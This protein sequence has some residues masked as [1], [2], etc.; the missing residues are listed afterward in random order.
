MQE[1]LLDRHSFKTRCIWYDSRLQLRLDLLAQEAIA[2]HTDQQNQA[3]HSYILTTNVFQDL[4]F[5][6]TN[7]T[8]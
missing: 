5:I 1:P 4:L 3:F 7:L 6:S 8:F 2:I